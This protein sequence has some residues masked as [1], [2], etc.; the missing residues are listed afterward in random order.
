MDRLTASVHERQRRADKPVAGSFGACTTP[1]MIFIILAGKNPYRAVVFKHFQKMFHGHKTE[2]VPGSGVCLAGI[3][4]ADDQTLNVHPMLLFQRANAASPKARGVR[5]N[6]NLGKTGVSALD[7]AFVSIALAAGHGHAENGKVGVVVG[8]NALGQLEVFNPKTLAQIEV[9]SV[10][11][12]FL[13]QSAG[14]ASV[15]KILVGYLE[16][17]VQLCA[18]GGAR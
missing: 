3:A 12:D 14:F 1:E 2:V 11:N 18:L 9:G 13:R 16:V 10:D 6:D 8:A 15:I 5:N 17:D 4:E 7:V